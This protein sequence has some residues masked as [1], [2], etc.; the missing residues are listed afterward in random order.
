MPLSLE[1]AR[2]ILGLH[3]KEEIESR[4]IELGYYPNRSGR[5]TEI[6]LHAA[7]AS[8]DGEVLIAGHTYEYAKHLAT[9]AQI[10]AEKLGLQ[11]DNIRAVP[12]LSI[13]RLGQ[14]FKDHCSR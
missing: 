3:P 14:V 8:Q 2:Q 4:S 13:P 5:T 11:P 1:E 9:K 12:D 10:M 7:V 6:L